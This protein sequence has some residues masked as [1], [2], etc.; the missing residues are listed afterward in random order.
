MIELS[1][2]PALLEANIANLSRELRNPGR[3]RHND[4]RGVR[5]YKQII[6]ENIKGVL[7]TVFPLFSQRIG[8]ASVG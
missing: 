1:S 5:L 6:R 8:K 3:D 7:S 2:P 4:T